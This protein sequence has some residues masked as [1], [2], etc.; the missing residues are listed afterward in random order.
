MTRHQA[1]LLARAGTLRVLRAPPLATRAGK[2]LPFYLA[3]KT[4]AA[5]R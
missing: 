1:M 2:V 4:A 3:P 5:A